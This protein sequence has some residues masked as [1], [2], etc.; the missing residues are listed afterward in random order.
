MNDT[1]YLVELS[2]R[3]VNANTS[4]EGASL[5]LLS[6]LFLDS[7]HL[8]PMDGALAL[9]KKMHEHFGIA[10]KAKKPCALFREHLNFR[11]K[12]LKEEADE[13]NK[14]RVIHK[15]ADA[16]IDSIIF[17]LGSLEQMGLL[18]LFHEMFQE[19]M[20]AN[21]QKQVV[22]DPKESKRGYGVDLKKP[23][24]WKAPNLKA[25]IERENA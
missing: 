23:K 6:R 10:Y 5:V 20:K 18:H 24:G 25:I 17:A 1:E 16:L 19:V 12:A 14:T 15:Q 9:V 7:K 13:L 4:L 22:N 8:A 21:M 3:E 11:V 2:K